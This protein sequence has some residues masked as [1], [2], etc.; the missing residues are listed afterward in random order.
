MFAGACL[1]LIVFTLPETYAPVILKGIAE[2]KRKETGD[3]RW[4][5]PIEV[6]MRETTIGAK[7]KDVLTKPMKMREWS[8]FSY[9]S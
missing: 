5:A 7:F 8:N 1:A 4:Y 3:D 6:Q 2:Q 9:D